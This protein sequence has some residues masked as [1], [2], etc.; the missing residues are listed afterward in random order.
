MANDSLQKKRAS[1]RYLGRME[2]LLFF[3]IKRNYTCSPINFLDILLKT[4]KPYI[5][6]H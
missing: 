4:Q 2:S 1:K 3:Y 6:N 5:G